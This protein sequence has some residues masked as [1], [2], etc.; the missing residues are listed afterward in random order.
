MGCSSHADLP[1]GFLPSTPFNIPFDLTVTPVMAML[2]IQFFSRIKPVY[3]ALVYSVL[4]SFVFQPLMA[5]FGLYCMCMWKDWYS[6]PIVFLIYLATDFVA[7]RTKF[8]AI[9]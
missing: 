2:F 4:D 6:F 8:E 3:K 7:T 1:C 5:P 9:K